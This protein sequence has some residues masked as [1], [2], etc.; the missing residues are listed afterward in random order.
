MNSKFFEK[1]SMIARVSR[2]SLA[3]VI[4]VLFIGSSVPGLFNILLSATCY[5]PFVVLNE[6]KSLQVFSS[7]MTGLMDILKKSEETGEEFRMNI[8]MTASTLSDSRLIPFLQTMADR[9]MLRTGNICLEPLGKP[10]VLSSV[11][12]AELMQS[13]RVFGYVFSGDDRP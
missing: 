10:E 11:E 5:A 3:M 6:K 4:P 2:A 8:Q 12:M 13:V 1:A 9:Y 7:E